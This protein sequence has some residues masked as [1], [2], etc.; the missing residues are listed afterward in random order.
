MKHSTPRTLYQ[1]LSMVVVASCSGAVLLPMELA[2]SGWS[3]E[4]GRYPAKY[5]A[6][7]MLEAC[8]WLPTISG[9]G[10][11]CYGTFDQILGVLYV[12][13]F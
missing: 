4:E 13:L 3:N 5:P 9:Q 6:R 11:T 1:L 12:A 10:E 7:I 2:Q 8:C